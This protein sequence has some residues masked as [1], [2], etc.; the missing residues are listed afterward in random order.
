MIEQLIR[1]KYPQNFEMNLLKE[2]TEV[3]HFRELDKGEVLI[4]FGDH[5]RFFPLLFTGVIKIIR[6]DEEGKEILLY[7]LYPGDSCAISL[8]CCM[9]A[10][11]S[12]IK[13]VVEDQV[14]MLAIPIQYMDQW[15]VQYPSWK[16]F[17]MQTYQFRFEE[18]LQTID[19]LAFNKMDDRLWSYLQNRSEAI[20][21]KLLEITH[22][23][24]AKELGTSREVISRLLKKLEHQ[25]KITMARNSIALLVDM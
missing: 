8:S 2:M 17:V 23:E 19:E 11:L 15:L 6:E 13:A 21:S 5:I 1:A 7:Y 12:S 14:E 4:G 3:G 16:Q 25:R 9:T 10:Q 24:I 22:L 18:L 20:Q